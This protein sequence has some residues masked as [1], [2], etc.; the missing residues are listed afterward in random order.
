[1]MTTIPDIDYTYDERFIAGE[2]TKDLYKHHA[3]DAGLDVTANVTIIIPA[4]ES[5]LIDTGVYI[6]IP[7]GFVGLLWSRSGLSVK[8][9]LEVGAGCIDS[10]YTGEVK[11]HLY[12]HSDEDYK[13][14]IGDKIAQLLTIPVNLNMYKKV[15]FLEDSDRG[16]KGF[17][18]SGK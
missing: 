6:N 5:R 14:N 8:Y 1:M 2:T 18:S 16:E 17:G 12:N 11:V 13:V 10:G 4:R 3:L 9:R 7:K 15:Q